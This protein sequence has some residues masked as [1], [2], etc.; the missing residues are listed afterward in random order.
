MCLVGHER[1]AVRNALTIGCGGQCTCQRSGG[2]GP[3]LPVRGSGQEPSRGR[4]QQPRRLEVPSS[5]SPRKPAA[6][7]STHV[8]GVAERIASWLWPH[9]ETVRL[10]ADWNRD[11]L[12]RGGV[13]DVHG[14]I[15]ASR[16]PETLAIGAD[17]AHVGAAALRDGPRRYNLARREV[18]HRDAAGA[19]RLA[20]DPGRA[21]VGH[22]ELR[23]VTTGIESVGANAGLDEADLL[24]RVAV[25]EVDAAAPQ[26]GDVKDLAV[27][28]DP[29][30]LGNA[31]TRQLEVAEDLA[32]DPVDLHESALV[33]ARH[34]QVPAV[35]RVVAVVDAGTSRS[36][37]RA[38]ERHRLRI[39]KVEALER[40]GHD[41]RRSAIRR[42]V[43]VVRIVDGHRG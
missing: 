20:A 30:V 29:E 32:V 15:I 13:D 3:R 26:L 2:C 34:D 6:P 9:R 12:A 21:A 25:D 19:A 8:A 10:L 40:F 7:W 43:P 24:E 16:E 41:D 1:T 28:A 38:L 27:G 5:R 22:I 14:V 35:D 18:D 33:F 42:E 11:D 37:Q 36:R 23:S 4:Q 31:A 39:A 17:V